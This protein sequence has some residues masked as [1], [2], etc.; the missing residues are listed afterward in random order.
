MGDAEGSNP[1]FVMKYII[2]T[3]NMLLSDDTY[4]R[5]VSV[6]SIQLVSEFESLKYFVDSTSPNFLVQFVLLRCLINWSK[7][8][9]A[10][11]V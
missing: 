6:T 11:F 7:Y 2:S 8:S 9:H 3:Y 4:Q 1:N 10:P 5:N